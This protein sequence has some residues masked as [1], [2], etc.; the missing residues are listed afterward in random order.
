VVVTTF[1]VLG[2][3]EVRPPGAAPAQLA[4][5]VRA[6]LARLAL[7]PGRVV[8]VDA[9][10]DALWGEDLPGDAANALQL[11]VSKLRRALVA[12]GVPGD[13]LV[14]QAPG[15][16]L[17]VEP[18]A[19]DAVR[20]ER[21]LARTRSLAADPAAALAALDEALALW[22]GPALADVGDAEWAAAEALRLDELRLGAREDRLELLLDAGRHAE[23]TGELERLAAL[24]P[25]RERLHG[26]L[27]LA[28]Y[29]AGRQAD[30]LAAYHRLRER[31]ADELGIDPSPEVQA[32]ATAV[33]R[34][35]VPGPRTPV[36]APTP[37]PPPAAP[38]AAPALP[39]RLSAVLGRGRDVATALQQLRAGR[40]VTL[41]G[42]GGVGKT[43]LALEVAR[44]AVP[45]VDGEVRLVRLA[46]VE[47]GGDVAEVMA[48]QLGVQAV[49]GGAAALAAVTGFVGERPLLLV[50]DN[51]E[52]VVDAAA[53]VVE[54]LLAACPGVR[55]LATSRE[56][57]AVP[58]EVQ[59]A[60]HPLD[61][62]PGDDEIDASPAVQ[63]FVERARAVRPSFAL[64][65]ANA[66]LVASIC[67]RL[68]GVPLALEL[69]AARVKALPLEDIAARLDDRFALL[70][71]GPRTAEARHRTLRAALDW[72]HDL[73]TDA[74]RTVLRR[75][76]VFRGGWT[77]GAAEDVCAGDGIER[78]EVLD[79]LLRLVD[80]SLVVSAADSGRFRLLVT[81]RDYAAER[82]REAGEAD[83]VRE[84]H[85]W[86]FT[87]HAQ[88]N[89]AVT[90][91]G[92][93]GWHRML[94]EHDNLRAALDFA[95][96][97]ARRAQRPEDVDAGLRLA[98]AMVWFWQYNL[99]HEGLAVLSA[100]LAL[101][102]GSPGGRALALQ[103]IALFH[104]YYPTPASRAAGRES[105][106]ILT[107]VGD[108][109][110]AA[111]SK[112]VLAWEGPYDADVTA[113]RALAAE[114]AAVLAA[115]GS[116]GMTA[117][118]HYVTALLDLG[119]GDFEASIAG[120]RVVL[121][122]LRISGD[123]VMQSAVLAHLGVSLRETG[124][125]DEALA[126][127]EW[128]VEHRLDGFGPHEDAMLAADRWMSHS[129]LSAP[130]NLGLL[131]PIEI[132]ERVVRAYHEGGARLSSVEG[133][134]RQVVG[135]RDYVWHVYWY[136]GEEYRG[137]DALGAHE[138]LPRWFAELDP[139][140][141][142]RANC[143]RHVLQAVREDGWTHHIQRLMVL[144]NWGLQRGYDAAELSQWFQRSFVDGY[145][146]VMLPNVV[147]MS[148]HAD[149]G[150]MATKPYAAGGAYIN[151]M[152]DYCG[153]CVY[154][155]RV[156][157]G[158]NACPFTAGYWAFLARNRERLEGNHRMGQALRGMDRL[159]DLDAVVA[160]E[161]ARGHS[162]P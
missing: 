69:A 19:V 126:A 147:G 2:P 120:W 35:Q 162:A 49:G 134:V 4:P 103:G 72:S 119:A 139:D 5:S 21:L 133:F 141:E 78:A 161:R 89:G 150:F 26:M 27:V 10:T 56:A 129:V 73:L 63:L 84:R 97:R 115:E 6:L 53:V 94:A 102:G 136:A 158:E 41:T 64:T 149:G 153:G 128:F 14:T 90:C 157:V 52:Q 20:F 85:L 146:W 75:L 81:I 104:V 118:V 142:V 152:S 54:Q 109:R 112:L 58:G 108:T 113:S 42:P 36:A 87:A 155:P 51:C 59:V 13:V 122:H 34:Q 44:A 77:V 7:A 55:V 125:S 83:A 60:V 28:L 123:R 148:Q 57:L 11:R 107:E 99:R 40:L 154:D 67:R 86:H 98:N 45:H 9:L 37:P 23:A 12:A 15:Y 76:S 3:V 32:L 82:L 130:I 17:A 71:A 111:V 124:R 25:L 8:S 62:P 30:A 101:P 138:P 117:L 92:G 68:D 74:E 114:A 46:A 143:L 38:P 29:R 50:V 79:L 100:L 159:R 91:W 151:R 1:G 121:E 131:H 160:Q 66:P 80:R 65:A 137:R 18:D 88:Q 145:D 33:L 116:N 22:R 95:L 96:D 106:A 24:H 43:T 135:W 48:R 47:P 110:S 156:R 61:L 132:A 140:R 16:R 70:T 31:L 105:L 127:L 144:G 93:D 39:A